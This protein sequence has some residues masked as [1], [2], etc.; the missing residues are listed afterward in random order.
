MRSTEGMAGTYGTTLETS[1]AAEYGN[2]IV[3]CSVA[4]ETKKWDLYLEL[5]NDVFFYG[6]SRFSNQLHL[7]V[8]GVQNITCAQ[9]YARARIAMFSKCC[10]CSISCGCSIIAVIAQ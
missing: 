3:V 6:V 4:S 8:S 2:C 9:M 10:D 7:C 1:S 5:H